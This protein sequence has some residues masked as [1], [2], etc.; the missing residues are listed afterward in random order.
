MADPCELVRR[1]LAA[2]NARDEAALLHLA[3]PDIVLRPLRWVSGKEY[4][5]HDGVRR[6]IADLAASPH[7]STLTPT[8]IQLTDSGL[9]VAEGMLDSDPV[10]FTGLFEIRDGLLATVRSYMSDRELLADLGLLGP[11]P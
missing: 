10:A 9:V 2:F 6:W 4:R 3:H 1:W 8:R 7:A 5:G 11:G